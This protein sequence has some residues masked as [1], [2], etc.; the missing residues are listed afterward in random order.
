MKILS[1][2]HASRP[3][4]RFR[5]SPIALSR[6][7]YPQSRWEPEVNT[8]PALKSMIIL[9]GAPPNF[10]LKARLRRAQG[11]TARRLSKNLVRTHNLA[12]NDPKIIFGWMKILIYVGSVWFLSIKLLWGPIYQARLLNSRLAQGDQRKYRNL[13][14]AAHRGWVRGDVAPIT[15]L[16][17]LR[18]WVAT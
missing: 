2:S 16:I 15:N 13:S 4:Q 3:N 12:R 11:V 8:S 6:W 10:F 5:L 1:R 14:W 17:V 18:T 7:V 9:Q